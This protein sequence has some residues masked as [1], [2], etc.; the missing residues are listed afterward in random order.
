MIAALAGCFAAFLAA[1]IVLPYLD[2]HQPRWYMAIGE[3]GI[4]VLRKPIIAL[5]RILERLTEEK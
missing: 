2:E 1:Y 3:W 5:I 4:K